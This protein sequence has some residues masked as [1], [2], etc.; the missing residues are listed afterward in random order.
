MLMQSDP[1]KILKDTVDLKDI[2]GSAPAAN[3]LVD[4]IIM[5][6]DSNNSI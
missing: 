6:E 2:K 5:R 4:S 3:K 1:K